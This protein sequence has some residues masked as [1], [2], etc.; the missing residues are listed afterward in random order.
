VDRNLTI[1][2]VASLLLHAVVGVWVKDLEPSLRPLAPEPAK[3]LVRTVQQQIELPKPKPP[4]PKP[5][6][7]KAEAPKAE[8]KAPTPTQ[9]PKPVAATTPRR[10]PQPKSD[11]PPPP[12]PP[13]P[14]NEPPPLVLS[15]TYGSGGDDGVAVQT[16]KEDVLGDPG[17]EANERNTR[18]RP[19]SDPIAKAGADGDEGDAPAPETSRKIE[20]ILAKPKVANCAGFV[21]WPAE[22]PP[23]GRVVTVQVMLD[24]T[25]EGKVRKVR[26]LRG[27]GEPFDSQAIK[28]I[29]RCPFEPGTRDGKPVSTKVGFAVDFKPQS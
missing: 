20:V 11:A 12:T 16:G 23:S 4:E 27:A 3:Q 17:V 10:A 21:E 15:Q 22:A 29:Q 18:R 28:D 2:I 5:E 7:P 24:I 6:P 14:S 9:A 25:A 13:P 19:S 8:A 26:I 1:G